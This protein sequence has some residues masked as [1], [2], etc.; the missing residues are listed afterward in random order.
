MSI[1][2]GECIA[3]TAYIHSGGGVWNGSM[4]EL[5]VENKKKHLKKDDDGDDETE[6]GG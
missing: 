1:Y 6:S 3:L 2:P 5:L 4:L